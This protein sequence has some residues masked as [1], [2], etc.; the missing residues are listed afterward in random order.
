MDLPPPPPIRA[1]I[2]T[3]Q[4]PHISPPR[5]E[6]PPPTLTHPY[7]QNFTTYPA[8]S[9]THA[10][11]PL[12]GLGS[13][14]VLPSPP[15]W[16]LPTSCSKTPRRLP[17]TLTSQTAPPWPTA[18]EGSAD[19]NSFTIGALTA[20]STCLYHLHGPLCKPPSR[21]ATLPNLTFTT[22]NYQANSR[23][24]MVLGFLISDSSALRESPFMG[25]RELPAKPHTSPRVMV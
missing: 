11:R 21:M 19:R 12:H 16:A 15:L 14:H 25:I 9:R 5:L 13:A 8:I 18:Y 1:T 10:H 22:R 24:G 2:N 7:R 4:P 6:L 3:P 23:C 17:P 20:P